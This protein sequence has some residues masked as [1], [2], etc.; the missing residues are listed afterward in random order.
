[1]TLSGWFNALDEMSGDD[2]GYILSGQNGEFGRKEDISYVFRSAIR[3][4]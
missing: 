3:N 4:N 1:M 2:V